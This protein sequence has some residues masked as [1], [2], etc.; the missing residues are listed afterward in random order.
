M[1]KA[2]LFAA[3]LAVA[4]SAYADYYIIG[5]NVNG[6]S[7]A[8]SQPDAKFEAIGNGLYKWEGQVLGTGFKL[9]DGTWD[10]DQMNFGSNGSELEADT[11]YFLG[12]GGSSGNIVLYEASEV[13]NPVVIFDENNTS[14]KITGDFGGKQ[15]WYIAG[16]NGV[17]AVDEANGT[18]LK[19][20]D[21]ENVFKAEGVE[22]SVEEGE[23][24]ISTTGWS[25]E[26][27]TNDPEL[28]ID[29]EHMNVVLE[30]VFGEAGNIPYVL[31]PGTYSFTF[32]HNSDTL[33]I[34]SEN[35]GSGVAGVELE[36]GEVGYYTL[37][38]VRVANP[39]KGIFVKVVGKKANKVVVD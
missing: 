2:L 28:V 4:S 30:E 24:K 39:Q 27:G 34:E 32:D 8:L 20:T 38:G 17:F 1:K 10:N 11:E 33:L 15:L 29:S 6:Q 26:Y 23:L 12:V 14:I 16:L 7:W 9:N 21:K 22:V 13:I 37:Q 3:A 18:E 5:S 19:P 35:G 31:T 36:E 25:K